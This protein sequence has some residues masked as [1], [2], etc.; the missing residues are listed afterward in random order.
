MTCIHAHED[1]AYVLG[2]LSASDRQRFEAHLPGCPSCSASVRELAGMPGLLTRV[3]LPVDEPSVPVPETL[4][5]SLLSRVRRR[6]RH[7]AV[8][9]SAAAASVAAVLLVVGLA[10][11]REP[12]PP[13]AAEARVM[14]VVGH[15][16][17]HGRLALRDTDDGTALRL[18][19]AGDAYADAARYL[20]VVR[21]RSGV[22]EQVASWRAR[23]GHTTV[24]DATT[25]Y[26]RDQLA[27]AEVRTGDGQVVLRLE[28]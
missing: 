21:T 7:L 8:A 5:P 27:G 23:P 28:I 3:D 11:T 9:W 15:D 6:R 16:T 26:S 10:A 12:S 4:L 25:A 22:V 20:L 19:C 2:A 13:T 1:A 18:W 14:E 17:L 24:L